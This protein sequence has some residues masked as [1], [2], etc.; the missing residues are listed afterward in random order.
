V[1]NHAHWVVA[2]FE[3]EITDASIDADTIYLL[4]TRAIRAAQFSRPLSP[5]A[6][7]ERDRSGCGRRAGH[8]GIARAK[9]GLYLDMLDAASAPA[10]SDPTP[11]R[12]IALPFAGTAPL[13]CNATRTA[14]CSR[15]L[16][17]AEDIGRSICRAGWRHRPHSQA[18]IDVG[19]Y[20]AQVLRHSPTARASPTHSSTGRD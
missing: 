2:G 11:G 15:G 9:D 3:D 14:L 18:A 17:H 7:G 13:A 16:A 8:R 20:E 1:A 10:A 5:P 19:G 12:G 6:V 4:A